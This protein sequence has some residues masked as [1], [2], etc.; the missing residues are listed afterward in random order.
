MKVWVYGFVL[1][2]ALGLIGLGISS[3]VAHDE[4]SFI[5]CY[6]LIGILLIPLGVLALRRKCSRKRKMSQ[7]QGS[8]ARPLDKKG[9]VK[10]A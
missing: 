4:L 7:A 6:L 5:V 9:E 10:T 2:L 3:L 1:G 8:R